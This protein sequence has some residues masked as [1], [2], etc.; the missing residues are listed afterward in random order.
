MFSLLAGSLLFVGCSTVQEEKPFQEVQKETNNRIGKKVE[1]SRKTSAGREIQ[2]QLDDLLDGKLTVNQAVQVALLKN[3][4]LQSRFEELG[5]TQAELVEAGVLSN[6]VFEGAAIYDAGE[7]V[8]TSVEVLHNFISV[9]ML[10]LREQL[11]ETRKSKTQLQVTGQIMDL[12]LS[13]KKTY[14]KLQA[15]RQKRTLFKRVNQTTGTS[16]E[17]AQELRKAGNI[18]KLDLLQERSLHE[19][20][21][22]DLAG[23]NLRVRELRKVLNRKM[24]V[25]RHRSDWRVSSDLPAVPE[26]S[27]SKRAT[28]KHAIKESLDLDIARKRV[29][30]AAQKEEIANVTSVFPFV[31]A[32]VEAEQEADGNWL[33]GPRLDIPI[34]LFNQGHPKRSIA[35]SRVRQAWQTYTKTAIRVRTALR[36]TRDRVQVHR[37][38]ALY[39]R[40]VLVP[41]QKRILNRGLL[42]F[43]GMFI[44]VFRLLNLKKEEIAIRRQYINEL[45][46]YWVA[47]AKLKQLLNG[48]LVEPS[49]GASPEPSGT[50]PGGMGGG[51]H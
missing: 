3:P 25:W 44:G 17:T 14:R 13:V 7:R 28:E 49:M 11:A 8:S 36:I 51:G 34:P 18:T 29:R 20:T 24:G 47:R 33:A 31:E 32:G 41:L 35:R 42:R 50:D 10:P 4:Q 30:A 48:R 39:Y 21:R 45:L 2:E 26:T 40:D 37:R 27:I 23:A 15:A 12:A 22:L 43:N 19:K 38:R 16:Y 1:W 46:K 9:V 5:I 6:P